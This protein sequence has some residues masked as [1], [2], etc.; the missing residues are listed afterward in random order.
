M[1]CL[2]SVAIEPAIGASA[3]HPENREIV[4]RR[5]CPDER[6][7]AIAIFDAIY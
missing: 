4:G 7:P 3:I 2:T 6:H 1:I 5:Y